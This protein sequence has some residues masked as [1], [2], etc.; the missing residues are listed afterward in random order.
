MMRPPIFVAVAAFGTTILLT[1]SIASA[2]GGVYVS[3]TEG[4]VKTK[5]RWSA[6]CA[7]ASAL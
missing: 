3:S 5:R 6:C 7:T 4:E 2:F 1:A